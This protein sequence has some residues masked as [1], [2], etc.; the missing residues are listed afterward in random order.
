MDLHKLFERVSCICS[1][2]PNNCNQSSMNDD[3]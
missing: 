2:Q 1:V 3:M